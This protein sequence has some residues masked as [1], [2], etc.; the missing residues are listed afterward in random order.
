MNLKKIILMVILGLSYQSMVHAENY[1]EILGVSQN[2]SKEEIFNA[3]N[4]LMLSA[5][6]QAKIEKLKSAYQT[7][8][9]KRKRENYDYLL[10]Q[11]FEIIER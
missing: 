5:T 6:T 4:D 9:D 2:A 1:Y 3:Y 11:G 7:L 8:K 10:E